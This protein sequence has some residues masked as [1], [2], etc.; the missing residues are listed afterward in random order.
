MSPY[1]TPQ[2][3]AAQKRAMYP[4]GHAQNPQNVPGGPMQYPHNQTNGVPVPMQQGYGRPGPMSA[5]GRGA[6]MM[7][8]QRQNTP[9]YN[10]AA[11]AAHGQQFYGGAGY[12]NLQGYVYT[13]FIDILEPFPIPY[14]LRV[15]RFQQDVRLSYQHSPVP[16]NP[17][18]PLTPASSMTPYVSPNP[19]IKPQPMH[20][21]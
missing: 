12:Q 16:G 13:I 7:P 11:A 8:Q 6:N 14:Q 3:H 15:H 9:P 18:P 2:M 17:T 20:S 19:D 10:Q 1:P 5:Y 4:M 21:K